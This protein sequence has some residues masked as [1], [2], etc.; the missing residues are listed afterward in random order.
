V[1]RV[2]GV[3]LKRLLYALF[4]ATLRASLWPLAVF[5]LHRAIP[6]VSRHLSSQSYFLNGFAM[7][8]NPLNITLR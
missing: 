8:T 5:A 7:R 6:P 4:G 3:P 1:P 2:W